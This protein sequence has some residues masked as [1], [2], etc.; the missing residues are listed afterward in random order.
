LKR[1]AVV[2]SL[3]VPLLIGLGTIAGISWGVMNSWMIFGTINFRMLANPSV[4]LEHYFEFFH[5]NPIT[6]FC[7]ISF[8]KSTTDCPYT[9]QLGVVLA[10]EYR[11]GNMNASLFATE[12]LA[13]IGP[14]WMPVAAFVCGLAIAAGSRASAGLPAR[15]ILISGAIVPHILLNVPLSTTLLSNGLGLLM[16]LWHLTPRSSIAANGL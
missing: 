15:F 6:K 8:L 16:L 12:G 2:L 5:R 13:S 14:I 9:D 7:Q 3:L 1:V 4:S 10:N 11:L